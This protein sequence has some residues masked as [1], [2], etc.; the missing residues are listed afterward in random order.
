M[1]I[2]ILKLLSIYKF[3]F[4]KILVCRE[5]INIKSLLLDS[6]LEN[7]YGHVAVSNNAN[8]FI[9]GGFNGILQNDIIKYSS[10]KCDH[11]L[12]TNEYCQEENSRLQANCALRRQLKYLLIIFYLK[13]LETV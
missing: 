13:N 2:K 12:K 3:K 1:L 5:W 8:M 6:L 7:R 4:K 10:V 9:I 11:Q